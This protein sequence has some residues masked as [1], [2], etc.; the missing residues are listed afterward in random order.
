MSPSVQFKPTS[1]EVL[2]FGIDVFVCPVSSHESSAHSSIDLRNVD[3]M[4]AQS[5]LGISDA[6]QRC[7]DFLKVSLDNSTG[8]EKKISNL[9][10]IDPN[11]PA[12]LEIF[13]EKL[14]AMEA[15]LMTHVDLRF[16][17]LELSQERNFRMIMERLDSVSI[18]NNTS[19]CS[20]A[21]SSDSKLM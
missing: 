9:S 8:Q 13:E 12:V 14:G 21:A 18:N 3:E 15:R 11:I 4:L 2:I 20:T 7:K 16:Q 10:A 6:A 1:A 5:H 17:A 19:T